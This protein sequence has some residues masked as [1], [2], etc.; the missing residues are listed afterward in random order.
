MKELL[1]KKEKLLHSLESQIDIIESLIV[2]FEQDE[3]DIAISEIKESLE[4]LFKDSM[5]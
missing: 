4:S 3:L 5:I 1:E 2:C